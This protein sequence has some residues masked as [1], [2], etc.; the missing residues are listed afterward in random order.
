MGVDLTIGFG[1]LVTAEVGLSGVDAGIGS[2]PMVPAVTPYLVSLTAG[3]GGSAIGWVY[4]SALNAVQTGTTPD[5]RGRVIAIGEAASG[6]G[7]PLAYILAGPLVE[8]LRPD[9]GRVFLVMAVW[10]IAG[11]A[12]GATFWRRRLA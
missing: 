2:R 6:F 10:L 3:L 8:M 11:W 4:V 9:V 5:V 1:L 7:T 12:L